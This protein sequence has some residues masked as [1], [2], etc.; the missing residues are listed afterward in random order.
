MTEWSHSP[1]S[2]VVRFEGEL[3]DAFFVSFTFDPAYFERFVLSEL[4]NRGA[5]VTVL[6]DA[7]MVQFDPYRSTKAG[8]TYAL[9]LID[10]PRAFHPKLMVL[11]GRDSTVVGVGSG[12]LTQSGWHRND[13]LWTFFRSHEGELPPVASA[14]GEWIIEI[15]SRVPLSPQIAAASRRVATRLSHDSPATS[16][17]RFF[18]N[19]DQSIL[20][21]LPGGPVG[22]LALFAPFHDSDARGLRKIIDHFEPS[23]VWL[24][25]QPQS[26]ADGPAIEALAAAHPAFELVPLPSNPYRHGKLLEW[27]AGCERWALTGS[28][29]LTDVA[30]GQPSS[31]GNVE[32]AVL[33]RVETSL[34]P[35]EPDET[36]G[37]IASL[38][39]LIDAPGEEADEPELS[40]PRVTAA[41]AVGDL[42]EIHLSRPTTS[43]VQFD[44]ADRRTPDI[45]QAVATGETGDT[46]LSVAL[47][48]AANQW[49]RIRSGEI[50]GPRVPISA[51]RSLEPPRV[52]GAHGYRKPTVQELFDDERLAKRF[53]DDYRRAQEALS[54][55]PEGSVAHG[56][57]GRGS[58]DGSSS[59]WE[60]YLDQLET[61]LGPSLAAFALGLPSFGVTERGDPGTLAAFD[62]DDEALEEAAELE[63]DTAESTARELEDEERQRK[64]E[65]DCLAR[66]KSGKHL[67]AISRRVTDQP[68]VFDENLDL[69]LLIARMCLTGV[70]GG[71]WR[72]REDWARI[73]LMQLDW[74]AELP[75]AEQ[76]N[77]RSKQTALAALIAS[78]LH[79]RIPR[80]PPSPLSRDVE[81][82]ISRVA[83]RFEQLEADDVANY[84]DEGLADRLG[85]SVTVEA[86]MDFAATVAVGDIFDRAVDTLA[87]LGGGVVAENQDPWL[88]LP[89]EVEDPR[90][91][92]FIAMKEIVAA[93]PCGVKIGP[94]SRRTTLLWVGRTLAIVEPTKLEGV[95]RANLHS[96]PVGQ[97]PTGYGTLAD[98][99]KSE[100]I[101]LESTADWQ[102]VAKLFETIEG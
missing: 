100:G 89:R 84:T 44:V 85:F 95:R 66:G 69:H 83:D 30:I 1:L 19:L 53:F 86:V 64:D 75:A 18:S 78:V 3:D 62:F 6:A 34:L 40:L 72:A 73:L 81:R 24:G 22:E 71:F 47:P 46:S 26:M 42:V 15:S 96:F 68:H 41:F 80:V 31:V 59:T 7:S 2:E 36:A 48:S 11:T 61:R 10:H 21:Q 43:E 5:R 29:N 92:G 79:H 33:S 63:D 27:S 37:S 52:T 14:V 101:I 87:G 12:N 74:F 88:F 55:Q 70:A 65:L 102:R 13:E 97:D 35:S 90:W 56:S 57:A 76:P 67:E 82:A 94:Y 58:A 93:S 98:L 32:I 77:I 17:H 28:P 45:W 8:L 54:I 60:E 38:R 99:P 91:I 25:F 39:L 50:T 16:N 49:I 9:G 20:S 23:R 4:R 51:V